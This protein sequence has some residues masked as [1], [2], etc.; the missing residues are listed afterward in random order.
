MTHLTALLLAEASAV[1]APPTEEA[2]AVDARGARETP[3]APETVPELSEDVMAG[4]GPEAMLPAAAL[5]GLEEDCAVR[6]AGA[7]RAGAVEGA[8][9]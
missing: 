9:A 8:G 1:S 5:G 7:L 3:H 2:G 4:E 6:A